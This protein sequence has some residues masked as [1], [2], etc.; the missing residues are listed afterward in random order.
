[1]SLIRY[2]GERQKLSPCKTNL[3][4]R[5]AVQLDNVTFAYRDADQVGTAQVGT[6]QV[7]AAQGGAVQV[8]AVG[9]PDAT[10]AELREAGL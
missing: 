6:D 9:K 2:S 7:G 3:G 5:G 4:V 1:M 8:G 10:E